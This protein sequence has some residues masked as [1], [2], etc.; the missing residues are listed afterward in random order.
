MKKVKSIL[1]LTALALIVSFSF[2]YAADSS[3]SRRQKRQEYRA[4]A[5][6]AEAEYKKTIPTCESERECKV[7]VA[8]ALRWLN[9]HFNTMRSTTG[10]DFITIYGIETIEKQEMVTLYKKAVGGNKYQF[11][12]NVFDLDL[13]LGDDTH[14]GSNWDTWDYKLDFNR[15]LNQPID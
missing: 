1:V 12:I 4:A 9:S 10:K 7:K 2:S 13:E 5:M 8:R 3:K 6:A 15:E 14:P 11:I